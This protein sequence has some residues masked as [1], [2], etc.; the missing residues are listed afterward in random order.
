[1]M[2]EL[3]PPPFSPAKP[4]NIPITTQMVLCTIAFCCTISLLPIAIAVFVHVGKIE[5]PASCTEGR[6]FLEAMQVWML[7]ALIMTG[8]LC[9]CS[10]L[11]CCVCVKKE[12]RTPLICL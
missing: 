6:L 11:S 4:K 1:M 5:A 12:V 7:V 8:A 10:A 9:L 2:T 3:P